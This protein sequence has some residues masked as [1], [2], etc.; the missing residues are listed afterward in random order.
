MPGDIF[1]GK[2]AHSVRPL[3]QACFTPGSVGNGIG[4][5]G[6]HRFAES[7]VGAVSYTHLTLPTTDVV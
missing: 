4:N 6:A 1:F 7:G 2:N 3:S 5:G